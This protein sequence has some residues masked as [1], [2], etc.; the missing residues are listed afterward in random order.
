[1]RRNTKSI[2]ALS[3]TPQIENGIMIGK[4]NLESLNRYEEEK[5]IEG[6]VL[7]QLHLLT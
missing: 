7:F 3:D 4:F 1:M 2:A 5:S 6:I